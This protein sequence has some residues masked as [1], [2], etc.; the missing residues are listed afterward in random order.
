MFQGLNYTIEER[1]KLRILGL[2]PAAVKTV[3]EEIERCKANLDRLSDNLD[4]YIYL[5]HLQVI[6]KSF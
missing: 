1:Q 3:Q 5:A 6:N 4:K 2:L